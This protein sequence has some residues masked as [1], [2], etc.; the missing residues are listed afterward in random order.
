MRKRTTS[1]LEKRRVRSKAGNTSKPID[2]EEVL[3]PWA[4]RIHIYF[5]MLGLHQSMMSN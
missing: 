1:K 5:N 3:V 2:I 4:D